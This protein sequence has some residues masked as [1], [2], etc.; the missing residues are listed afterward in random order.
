MQLK[1]HTGE[2]VALDFSPDGTHLI[3]GSNDGTA[4]I[5]D[6]ETGRGRTLAADSESVRWVSYSAD[7]ERVATA[8]A[9][10][11][12]ESRPPSWGV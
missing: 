7:N 5:W 2:I 1:G 4:R 3:S 11:V 8:G 12:A 6:L 9:D 10:R